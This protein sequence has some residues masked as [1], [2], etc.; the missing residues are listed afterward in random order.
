[1]KEHELR[2]VADGV[3]AYLQKGGWGFSNAGLVRGGGTSL[4]VDTLYDLRLTAQMLEE[5][6]R[7]TSGAPIDTLVN[8][9][10][11]GDH[12]W[13]NQLVG[14]AKIVSSRAAAE[15][16][17]E[18]SP[19][20]MKTL[21]DASRVV[22]GS[23]A[24][25]KTALGLLG[26]LGV[27][28]AS[29]MADAAAFVV[30]CFGAFDFGDITLTLP[31]AT[32][33]G[34]LDIDVGGTRV[35]LVQVG[36]AHTKGDVIVHLPAQ[37]VAFTGDILFIGSHPIVW[38]GPVSNWVAAC[39]RLLALD[40]DVIVPGHGPVTT[41]AGVEQ[42]KAYW[43]ELIA[44]VRAGR[45]SGASP[46]DV[47]AE[48]HRKGHLGWTEGSRVAVNVDTIWR[49]LAGDRTHPDPFALMAKMARL[50]GAAGDT[51]ARR[52]RDPS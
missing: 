52:G 35:E 29:A 18:L 15:E 38:Q 24:P 30:D 9:H 39:N 46:D 22:A 17:L 25:L 44:A 43:E 26:R 4:L 5:M 49:E 20:L 21:V 48:L 23:R 2:E 8:T 11:N 50:E 13:G 36:P 14:G 33:E 42:T 1:M 10:A 16:M 6:R 45:E 27:R 28:R 47:A 34:R 51:R 7:A 32:F 31:T 37:R 19:K 12:C 41:K 40:V 3:F